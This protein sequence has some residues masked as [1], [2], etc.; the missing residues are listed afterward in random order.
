MD[1]HG[2]AWLCTSQIASDCLLEKKKHIKVCKLVL[3]CILCLKFARCLQTFIAEWMR[4]GLSCGN[5]VLL[6]VFCGV[7]M[8]ICPS[9]ELLTYTPFSALTELVIFLSFFFSPGVPVWLKKSNSFWEMHHWHSLV[10]QLSQCGLAWNLLNTYAWSTEWQLNGRECSQT[11]AGTSSDY[12]ARIAS[13][14]I[15]LLESSWTLYKVAIWNFKW[16]SNY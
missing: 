15:S 2:C 5:V 3:S 11:Y 6:N 12:V 4:E 1:C 13:K 7:I 9:E 8:C 10:F 14:L 16:S